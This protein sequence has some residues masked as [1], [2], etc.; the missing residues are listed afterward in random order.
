MAWNPGDDSRF[1]PAKRELLNWVHS[2]LRLERASSTR[3]HHLIDDWKS[4]RLIRPSQS[5]LTDEERFEVHNQQLLSPTYDIFVIQHDWA[6]AFEGSQDFKVEALSPYDFHLPY[7][8]CCFE[9]VLSGKS[10]CLLS[11]FDY[12]NYGLAIFVNIGET[13]L[14]PPLRW[15]E[16]KPLASILDAQFRAIGIALEAQVAMTEVVRAS[17]KLNRSRERSGRQRVNDYHVVKLARRS[18]P[19]PLPSSGEGGDR[20]GVRLHFRR[21]HWRH[22]EEHKTWIKWTLVGDP[23]LGFIE[24][25]YS[26]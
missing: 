26:I 9:F 23:D 21:G 15:Q 3:F 2:G 14:Q 18:R 11:R 20:S 12:K 7:P 22:F 16:F 5:S 25:H 8:N 6:R 10:V 17:A 1:E 4:G 19:E 13:W 24:K